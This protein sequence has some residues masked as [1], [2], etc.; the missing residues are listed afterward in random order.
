MAS[1]PLGG[2]RLFVDAALP[3]RHPFEVLDRVRHICVRPVDPDVRER[4]IEKT[5]RGTDERLAREVFLVAGLLA[6]EHQ[7]R[8]VGMAISEDGL[9]RAFVQVTCTAVSGLGTKLAQRLRS[10]STAL[11]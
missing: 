10:G 5:P 2:V 3:A 11:L 9:R 4:A 7:R 1:A 8:C 6:D